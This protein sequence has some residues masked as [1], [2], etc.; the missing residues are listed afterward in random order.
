[1][2]LTDKKTI[3]GE[4]DNA[5]QGKKEIREDEHARDEDFTEES[6]RRMREDAGSDDSIY[7]VSLFVATSYLVSRS[8]HY[9]SATTLYLLLFYSICRL[10]QWVT[11]KRSQNRY[12]D[13]FPWNVEL[14][15]MSKNRELKNVAS[16]DYVVNALHS[17]GIRDT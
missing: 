6:V 17:A 15:W 13:P 4:N 11:M 1:M 7:T 9:V 16:M 8:R 12:A 14:H 5:I 10:S 2:P 3:A